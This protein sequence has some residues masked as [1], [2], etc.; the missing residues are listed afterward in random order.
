MQNKAAG[1][2]WPQ[3]AKRTF[4]SSE[5]KGIGKMVGEKPTGTRQDLGPENLQTL[6][7][8]DRK[9]GKRGRGSM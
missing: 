8:H 5:G 1:T 7:R 4:S 6:K 2:R 9:F 3:D